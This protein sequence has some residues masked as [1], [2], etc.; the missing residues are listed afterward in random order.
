MQV[1]GLFLLLVLILLAAASEAGKNKKA[2]CKYKFESWGGCDAATGLKARSGTLK[3]ALYNA[4]CQ[5]TIQVT[6]PCSPK[7]KSKS[8]A[9]KGKGK[10]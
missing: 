8:K 5:E 7:T 9:R 1:R 6:K 3:K 4:E 2:D 10:D